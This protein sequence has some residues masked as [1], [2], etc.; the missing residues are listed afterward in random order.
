ME[1]WRENLSDF[2]RYCVKVVMFLCMFRSNSIVTDTTAFIHFIK[3]NIHSQDDIHRLKACLRV[4]IGG[5]ITD[6]LSE[7]PALLFPPPSSSLP[8]ACL[9]AT[10]SQSARVPL[11]RLPRVNDG[12][13]VAGVTRG[14]RSHEEVGFR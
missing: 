1:E 13:W 3:G 9:F 8:T 6:G 4:I 14:R 12:P 7:E 5:S 10:A 11:G 2:V